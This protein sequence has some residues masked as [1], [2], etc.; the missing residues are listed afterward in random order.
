MQFASEDAEHLERGVQRIRQTQTLSVNQVNIQPRP[1]LQGPPYGK[2][3]A[4]VNQQAGS[5][6]G[7]CVNA[8]RTSSS[9]LL[10]K[11]IESGISTTTH[12]PADDTTAR[13]SINGMPDVRAG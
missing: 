8:R 7:C 4:E 11:E 9:T 3:T 12:P 13:A 6:F 1:H 5:R 10:G 2:L